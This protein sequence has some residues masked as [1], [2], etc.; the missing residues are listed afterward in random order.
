MSQEDLF[1]LWSSDDSCRESIQQ[2]QEDIFF[3]RERSSLQGKEF[4]LRKPFELLLSF[5]LPNTVARYALTKQKG[6]PPKERPPD[7]H[8]GLSVQTG[9][10]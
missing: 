9:I 7:K 10:S 6:P 1:P 8:H 5:C 4:Y 2:L 3:K